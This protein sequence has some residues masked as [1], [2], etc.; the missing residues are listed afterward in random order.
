MKIGDEPV[1][2]TTGLDHHS[3]GAISEVARW[4]AS[5]PVEKRPHPIVPM[6]R[7]RFGLSTIE[8]C[9]AIKEASLIEG[10]RK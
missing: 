9:M 7:S 6:I 2:G 4:L 8:A 1:G 3:S 10:R 5:I